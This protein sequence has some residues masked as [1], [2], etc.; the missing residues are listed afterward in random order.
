MSAANTK[1]LYERLA[2]V[3]GTVGASESETLAA[4]TELLISTVAFV[5][6]RRYDPTG[7]AQSILEAVDKTVRTRLPGVLEAV[8]ADSE[9]R[10]EGQVAT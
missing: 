10:A 7:A 8:I 1:H 6:A 4:V 5:A 9:K 3:A 2:L